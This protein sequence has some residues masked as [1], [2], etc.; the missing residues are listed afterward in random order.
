MNF[1]FKI[2]IFTGLT[3][4]CAFVRADD[5]YDALMKKYAKTPAEEAASA[6]LKKETNE[7]PAIVEKKKHKSAHAK[8]H[9][10]N[11]DKKIGEADK[12]Q[13]VVV[14]GPV[15]AAINNR[16][17]AAEKI[18]KD[19]ADN[20]LGRSRKIRGWL[21]ENGYEIGLGYKLDYVKNLSGGIEKRGE[22]LGNL[23]L[24]LNMDLEKIA[25]I[26]GLKLSLYGLFDHGNDPS[27][28]VGDGLGT[29]NIESPNTSKLYE[30]Y[31]EQ[32]IDDRFTLLFGIHDLNADFYASD[33]SAVFMSGAFGVSPSLSQTG[34]NGPSIF[35]QA[36]LALNL[37]YQ[38]ENSWYFKNGIFNATA[39]DPNNPKGT[40]VT[41]SP[42]N[43]YLMIWETGF[44]KS[45]EKTTY[46]YSLGA[47]TYT[48]ESVSKNTL[49]PNGNNSGWY[50]MADRK[51]TDNLS[52]FI[53]YGTADKDFNMYAS[54]AELGVNYS[55]IISSRPEDILAL[56]YVHA[57][58]S[59][60]Y[61]TIDS[62]KASESLVELAYKVK[63]MDGI[64]LMPD[65]QKVMNPSAV[66]NREN[67]TVGSIRLDMTF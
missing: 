19:V 30:A 67:A 50:L 57:K 65:L 25:L 34:V 33:T 54:C 46:K 15:E 61:Q 20:I 28:Y 55:G 58:V 41:T 43:G 42:A 51:L 21:L 22:Y 27:E 32:S 49:N 7:K 52:A 63:I 26:K 31:F 60:D 44:T 66:Q 3:F 4:S 13:T 8:K 14:K 11:A 53:K 38:S 9:S 12:A 56:G 40:H 16:E 48:R 37:K 1:I 2:S 29:N 5:A 36:A 59:E 64:Y 24:K 10:A 6:T 17:P 39:G 47:W 45:D 23:D 35:P 62:L 18:K